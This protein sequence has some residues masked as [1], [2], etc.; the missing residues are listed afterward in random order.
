MRHVNRIETSSPQGPKEPSG[1]S[2]VMPILDHHAPL[3]CLS[4]T[5]LPIGFSKLFK[6]LVT[7]F[8]LLVLALLFLPWQQFIS[9]TGKVVAFDPKERSLVVEAPLAGRVDAIFVMEGQKVN[10]G[11]MLFQVVDNDPNLMENLLRQREAML[12]QLSAAKARLTRLESQTKDL[13]ASMPQ[14]IL[15]AERQV[16]AAKAA[17]LA[18]DQQFAR[19]DQLFKDPRGLV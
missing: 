14:A 1:Y 2:E 3:S 12:S 11:D 16:E 18:A 4:R 7:V 15:I 17:K 10:K 9:G 13:E 19:M 8:V 5:R 6:A